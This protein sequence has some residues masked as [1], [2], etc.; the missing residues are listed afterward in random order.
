MKMLG[1]ANGFI[2]LPYV[3]EGYTLGMIGAAAAFGLEWLLYDW[4]L[5]R[6]EEVDTLKLFSFVPFEQLLIPM[7]STFAAAGLFVG[8][9]GSWT[10]IRK[11]LDV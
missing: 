2:R 5:L 8:I 10:S 3:V 7:V 6:L 11:F 4:L 9:V 1:A